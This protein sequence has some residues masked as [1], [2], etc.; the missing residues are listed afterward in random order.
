MLLI[1]FLVDQ[2]LVGGESLTEAR[3]YQYAELAIKAGLK[4]GY[5]KEERDTTIHWIPDAR[6]TRVSKKR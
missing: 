1:K 4:G 2:R 3:R 6:K 5:L